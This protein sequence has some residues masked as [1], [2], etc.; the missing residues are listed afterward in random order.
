M[1][2]KFDNP[3]LEHHPLNLNEP[4]MKIE[5]LLNFKRSSSSVDFLSMDGGRVMSRRIKI[6]RDNIKAQSTF[7]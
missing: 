5:N 2:A 6:G 3:L 4:A 7:R 1:L